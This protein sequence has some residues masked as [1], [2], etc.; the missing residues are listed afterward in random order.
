MFITDSS[1]QKLCWNPA[2]H[3][4]E[5]VAVEF[6]AHGSVDKQKAPFREPIAAT[7]EEAELVIAQNL[8]LAP[9]LKPTEVS[10]PVMKETSA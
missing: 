9:V 1:W 6:G 2:A 5:P 3:G 10:S 8:N 4:G 7:C